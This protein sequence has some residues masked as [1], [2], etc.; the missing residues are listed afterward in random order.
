[1][2]EGGRNQN[3]STHFQQDLIQYA[4]TFYGFIIITII[5]IFGNLNSPRSVS[6]FVKCRKVHERDSP[7]PNL[8]NVS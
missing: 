6:S 4:Q 5:I 3:I 7:C 8:N 1:M 2:E